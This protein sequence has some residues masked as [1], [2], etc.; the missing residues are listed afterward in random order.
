MATKQNVVDELTD[1][2]CGKK[3]GSGKFRDVYV[4]RENNS[5]VVKVAKDGAGCRHNMM[6][7]EVWV[8]TPDRLAKWLAPCS[9]ISEYGSYLIQQRVEPIGPEKSPK[10]VPAFFADTHSGNWGYLKGKPVC[11][12]YGYVN[13]GIKEPMKLVTKKW[14][15]T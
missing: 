5:Y 4:Y 7:Y 2:I 12:D 14:K 13:P 15:F 1:F 9:R 10:R 3:L 11:V 6:E 8:Q